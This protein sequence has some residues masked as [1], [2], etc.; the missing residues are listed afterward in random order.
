MAAVVEDAPNGIQVVD[1][2]GDAVR[3]VFERF[4]RTFRTADALAAALH[5]A[6][7]RGEVDE[8]AALAAAPAF[9]LEQLA[10]MRQSEQTTLY[11]MMMMILICFEKQ[12]KK[13]TN[14]STHASRFESYSFS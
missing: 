14:R 7:E 10:H 1:E 9:Y 8:E 2:G 12:E 3:A 13:K 5:A 6:A 4:L 11:G